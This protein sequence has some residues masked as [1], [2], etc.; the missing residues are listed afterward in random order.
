[1]SGISASAAPT[2]TFG[3]KSWLRESHD[4]ASKYI[5]DMC[6]DSETPGE[7]KLL[8]CDDETER[9]LTRQLKG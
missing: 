3:V 9:E 6:K 7:I 2:G 8:E 4:A 1:M 5:P